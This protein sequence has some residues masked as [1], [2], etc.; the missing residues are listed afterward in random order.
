MKPN[1]IKPNSGQ[2][3]VWDYPRPPVIV[4]D[5][6]LVQVRLDGALIAQTRRAQRVLE[7]ASPP[8]F[9]LPPEA[10]Q[11]D[12]LRPEAGGTFCEW[13]GRAVYFT[14]CLGSRCVPHAAWSYPEPF[15]AFAPIRDYLAFYPAAL[16]CFVA[17][18]R[19]RAQAGGYY[20]GWITAGILGPFKGEPGSA[21]W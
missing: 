21:G 17:G 18:E 19:V 11:A 3:S 13:K 10:V 5:S 8:T 1:P 2:E 12:C 9:Y 14:V 6:R 7:T 20:G 15:A 4:A 16:E